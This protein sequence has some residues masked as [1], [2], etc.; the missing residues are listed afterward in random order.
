MWKIAMAHPHWTRTL[1][2]GYVACYMS[3]YIGVVQS[4]T[5]FLKK[6]A[7]QPALLL[8]AADEEGND[9]D[10]RGLARQAPTISKIQKHNILPCRVHG[11][12]VTWLHK[13]S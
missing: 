10:E 3:V 8:Q 11:Y 4:S 13:T 12:M 2:W 9:I 5:L 7:A 1:L 6:Q